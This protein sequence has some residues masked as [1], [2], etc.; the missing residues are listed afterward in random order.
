MIHPDSPPVPE[1]LRLPDALTGP[2]A[3]LALRQQNLRVLLPV[4]L[5]DVNGS[6]NGLAL[7]SELLSR[8]M[9][10]GLAAAAS[11]GDGGAGAASLLQ[12]SRNELGRLKESLKALENRVLPGGPGVPVP[13][14]T[15]LAATLREVESVTMP[16]VRRA[17]L[18]WQLAPP[19]DAEP[20]VG[21]RPDEAFDLVAG[22]A[23]VAIESAPARSQL[24]LAARCEGLHW[25]LSLEHPGV[26]QSTI[27][28]ELHRELL[29]L[30]AALAGG[31][32]EWQ[33][34]P[35]GSRARLVL[36]VAAAD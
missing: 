12:R 23:I 11:A 20:C 1:P 33:Q 31:G 24:G 22:F 34:F 29:R 14:R 5:H 8:L 30:V 16:A 4:L 18:E 17:Q 7:A 15:A 25:V 2:V 13:R 27:G 28:G 26:A 19:I 9:S 35:G 10:A 3:R 21:L 32:A 36:P 6:L